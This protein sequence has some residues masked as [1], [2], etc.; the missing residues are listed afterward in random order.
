MYIVKNSTFSLKNVLV[1]SSDYYSD[2]SRDVCELVKVKSFHSY[3]QGPNNALEQKFI[4]TIDSADEYD[5]KK[6][7]ILASEI[8]DQKHHL[9]NANQDEIKYSLYCKPVPKVPVPE[10]KKTSGGHYRKSK[11][12]Q[13]KKR[14]PKK[15]T[16]RRRKSRKYIL[17]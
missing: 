4:F 13:S 9:D 15:R 1:T 5:D 8:T 12:R 7:I 17:K 2:H 3:N 11:K 10:V 6:I 14:Q 16:T